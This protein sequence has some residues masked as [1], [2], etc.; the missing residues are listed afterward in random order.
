MFLKERFTLCGP[1]L[2][3]MA[4]GIANWSL[5]RRGQSASGKK[6]WPPLGAMRDEMVKCALRG[7]RA[8]SK[9]PQ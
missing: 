5:A 8:V 2:P 3:K 6:V 1:L 7:P 4:K 9:K